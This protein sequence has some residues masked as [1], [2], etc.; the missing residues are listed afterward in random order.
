ML[1]YPRKK[2]KGHPTMILTVDIGNTN[3]GLGGFSEGNLTFVAKIA[4]NPH[5]T[6][7][8]YACKLLEIL[9]LHGVEKDAVEGA[10]LSSVVPLITDVM[11]QALSIAYGV[12]PMTVGPGIK[13]GLGIRCD[14][15]VSVGADLICACVAAKQLYGCPA[16]IVDMGTATKMMVVDNKGAFIGVSIIPG[17][18]MGLNALSAGTAQLPQV[19]LQAPPAAIGKN[20]ADCMR[21]GVV[22]GNAAMVDGMIRRMNREYGETLPVIATGGAAETVIPHCESE[23]TC[24]RHLVLKGLHLLYLRNN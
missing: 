14:D 16:L 4:S 2:R 22:Y 3:I 12:T 7:D 23:I 20:T 6:G 15:P 10:I 8:E 9:S 17:V 1:L 18:S 21:S 5:L 24:D 19:S 11:K 13:T